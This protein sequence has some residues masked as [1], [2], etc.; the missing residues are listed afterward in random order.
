[1][2]TDLETK[3]L[4]LYPNLTS[5][6]VTMIITAI[7]DSTDPLVDPFENLASSI[8]EVCVISGFSLSGK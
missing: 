2:A 5:S 7:A 3:I 4:E 1:M 6:E 8:I